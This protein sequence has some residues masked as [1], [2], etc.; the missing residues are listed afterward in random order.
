DAVAPRARTMS[1]QAATPQSQKG[2][3]LPP[4]DRRVDPN[5]R[6]Y[7]YL[8]VAFD[9][10][11]RI[12]TLVVRGP[13][14]PPPASVE[15]MVAQGAA[16]WP[17]ALARELDDAILDIRLNEFDIATI[18]LK[19]VG[20]PRSVL[21]YDAFLDTNK[22][23]WLAREVRLKWRRVLKRID[24]TSRTLVA[25]I[26]PGSCFAGTLAELVFAADRSYML[27]GRADGDNR[28]PAAIMLGDVNMAD[29]ML[30]MSNG[31]T[32][33][34]TRFLDDPA[35]SRAAY[36]AIGQELDAEKAQQL[37]LVTFALD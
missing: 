4:L 21:A 18:V 23:H 31:L 17:L 15:E 37:G 28:P 14:A 7:K 25:L 19:S 10:A 24:M 27:I 33:L 11:A 2:I 26:E 36:Q 13:D 30:P 9:R 32:R 35:A 6:E 16:F 1:A 29:D 3:A 20:E 5:G 12:A 22:A 34:A 8:S